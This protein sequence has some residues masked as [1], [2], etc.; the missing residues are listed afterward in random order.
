MENEMALSK[1]AKRAIQ[2][3]GEAV[4]IEA[5]EAFQNRSATGTQISVKGLTAQET[6]RAIAT[7]RELVNYVTAN[8]A[9]IL[10]ALREVSPEISRVNQAAGCTVF[11][12]T[13]TGMVRS[14]LA[15]VEA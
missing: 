14:I 13:A 3:H 12:P 8:A 10:A 11:N 7:G 1:M 4:C 5:F 6:D 2:A 9:N 15:G